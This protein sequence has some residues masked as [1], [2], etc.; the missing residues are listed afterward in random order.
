[1]A[2]FC[3]A[4]RRAARATAERLQHRREALALEHGVGGGLA[5]VGRAST[6]ESE[7]CAAA[8]AGASLRPS[9]TISTLRPCGL[10][11]LEAGDLVGRAARRPC[12]SVDA[13]AR[14]GGRAPTAGRSPD[15]SSMAKPAALQ[16]PR[17]PRPHRA[18]ARSSKAKRDRRLPS[19]GA[20]PERRPCRAGAAAPHQARR[21]EP[22]ARRR[23]PMRSRPEARRPRARRPAGAT[24][25]PR[26]AR[27]APR[28]AR[29]DGGWRRR[30][31]AARAST[32][33]LTS[34]A[35]RP[36]TARR[37]SACRSCRTRRCRP[38]PAARARPAP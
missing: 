25:S 28:R 34:L 32:S 35:R 30:G 15:S 26:L 36:A 18:A 24:A 6:G 38:R 16:A 8:S 9:P 7:A 27:R 4:M 2:K 19:A 10:Q 13:G 22:L 3:S 5:D 23:G 1:M 17:R 33:S 21:A 20:I 14:G 29:R 11:R 31:A 37:A 12:Q